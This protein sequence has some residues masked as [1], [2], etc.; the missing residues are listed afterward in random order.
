MFRLIKKLPAALTRL[1][2]FLFLMGIGSLIFT[3][4]CSGFINGIRLLKA[5]DWPIVEAQLEQCDPTLSR[6]KHD[7]YWQLSAVWQ[8]GQGGKLKRSEF[9]TLNG[10]PTY[11]DSSD[12]DV[13]KAHER[14]L[15][16]QRYCTPALARLRVSP[17][18]PSEAVRNNA[19]EH[20]EWKTEFAFGLFGIVFGPLMM[21]YS[22]LILLVDERKDWHYHNT[23]RR[24]F[25]KLKQLFTRTH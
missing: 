11:P 13:V 7:Y 3:A 12:P 24:I 5:Y 16:V 8:Y 6:G 14:P 21:G 4:A 15:I 19:V 20:G 1:L 25:S 18:H 10:A 22:L 17:A 23:I 9:W 2:L